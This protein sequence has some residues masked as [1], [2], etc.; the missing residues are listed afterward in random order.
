MNM[1]M[2]EAHIFPRTVLFFYRFFNH[3]FFVIL[4]HV[5]FLREKKIILSLAIF[6]EEHH[7]KI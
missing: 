1:K 7:F 4:F 2:K 5:H 6:S 3:F